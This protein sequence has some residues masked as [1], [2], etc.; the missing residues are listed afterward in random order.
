M[1]KT[2][3]LWFIVLP[4]LSMWLGWGIRGLVGHSTGAM[5]P[6]AFAALAFSILLPSKQFSRGLAIALTAVGFGYGADMTTLQVISKP[7]TTG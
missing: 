6:G 3:V 4:G 2:R 7:W 1:T 5:I